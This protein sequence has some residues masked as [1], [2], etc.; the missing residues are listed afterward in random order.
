MQVIFQISFAQRE[1]VGRIWHL[2][3]DISE[4][5]KHVSDICNELV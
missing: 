5:Q 2:N 1:R 3:A 4:K